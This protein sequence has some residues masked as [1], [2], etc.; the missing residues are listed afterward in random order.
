VKSL[1]IK[2][3]IDKDGRPRAVIKV[4]GDRGKAKLDLSEAVKAI[5]HVLG[6]DRNSLRITLE[7]KVAD[8]IA[9]DRERL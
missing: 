5:L 3:H 8:F 2:R 7:K 9:E 6:E 1:K 4:F